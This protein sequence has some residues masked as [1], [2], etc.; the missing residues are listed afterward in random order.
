MRFIHSL[1][2]IS[3]PPIFSHVPFPSPLDSR[4]KHLHALFAQ[5]ITLVVQKDAPV[6]TRKAK[7]ALARYRRETCVF[8]V[9]GASLIFT[10]WRARRRCPATRES[11][12]SHQVTLPTS[13]PRVWSPGRVLF[14][15]EQPVSDPL[16]ASRRDDTHI[17]QLFNEYMNTAAYRPRV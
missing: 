6:K 11:R 10:P 7:G 9:T 5:T 8:P 2:L 4:M 13:W 12:S 3:N 1:G 16:S 17:P 14:L 15:R